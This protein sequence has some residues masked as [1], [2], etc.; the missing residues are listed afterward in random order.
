MKI[1]CANE[2]VVA[3]GFTNDEMPEA[4]S[5]ALTE[6]R[7]RFGMDVR[8][9]IEA[10]TWDMSYGDIHPDGYIHV[11]VD[12]HCWGAKRKKAA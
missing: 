6:A 9:K 4:L 10:R 7:H 12:P 1:G 5:R 8:F 2:T 11:S 3:S